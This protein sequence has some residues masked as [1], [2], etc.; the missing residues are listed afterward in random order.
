MKIYTNVMTVTHYI[1]TMIRQKFSV[2][3][4]SGPN[5]LYIDMIYGIIKVIFSPSWHFKNNIVHSKYFE[6]VKK[7]DIWKYFLSKNF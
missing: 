1:L 7:K 2:S 4:F 6:I 3:A 5:A